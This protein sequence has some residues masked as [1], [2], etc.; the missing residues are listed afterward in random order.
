MKSGSQN[1]HTLIDTYLK[2]SERYSHLKILILTP[3]LNIGGITTYVL[4]VSSY[5]VSQGHE[6]HIATPGGE[7]VEEAVTIGCRIVP[8][9]LSKSELHPGLLKTYKILK[10]YVLAN[11][12][13]VLHCQSRATQ[14]LGYWL[15]HA[16]G[17]AYVSTCHGLMKKRIHRKLFPY[18]GKHPIAVSHFVK[19]LMVNDARA[20]ES[21]VSVIYHGK[22][23]REIEKEE[24]KKFCEMYGLERGA[25]VVGTICRLVSWKG[26]D[27][28]VA[29]VPQVL[30]KWPRAQFVIVG[31][32]EER[33]FLEKLVCELKIKNNIKFIGSLPKPEVF[34]SL[35]DMC[36]IPNRGSESFGFT[37]LEAMLYGK[38]IVLSDLPAMNEI[39]RGYREAHVVSPHDV[40]AL[41]EKINYVLD[42]LTDLSQKAKNDA[43]FI[44]QNFSLTS[45]GEK[46]LAIYKRSLN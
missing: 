31:E 36:V 24:Q 19:G 46:T 17:A 44:R 12:I 11:K 40:K 33:P 37:V 3:K 4:N 2:K 41:A 45:M 14:V 6:V 21:A 7:C 9:Q 10:K 32:G 15:G 23:Y 16:T 28:L 20:R 29:A 26:C 35:C 13:Q 43:E 5:L 38:P 18:W 1:S 39:I 34:Y 30:Q 27:Y 22:A 8:I 42:S 25:P